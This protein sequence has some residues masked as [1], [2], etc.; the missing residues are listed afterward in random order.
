M[1]DNLIFYYLLAFWVLCLLVGLVRLFL[2][3]SRYLR[4]GFVREQSLDRKF[5]LVM[6]GKI[7]KQ[8]VI[9]NALNFIAILL[10][11][12]LGIFF[13][14]PRLIGI[15]LIIICLPLIF[16][17]SRKAERLRVGS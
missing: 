3:I 5:V 4:T 2:Q 8:Y 7:A 1:P 15:L 16:I 6:K 17:T 13:I 14:I 11:L 9:L 10:L 12:T